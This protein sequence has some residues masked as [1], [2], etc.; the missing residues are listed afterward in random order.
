MKGVI[1]RFEGEFA[2]IEIDGEMKDIN[3]SDVDAEAKE[4]DVVRLD[5]GV[6]K[7]DAAATEARSKSV[8]KR[9]DSLLKK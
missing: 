2:I 7:K 9:F 4:G 1:D 6:W 5:N 3:R 8:K